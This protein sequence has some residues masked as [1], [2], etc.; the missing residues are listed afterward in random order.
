MRLVRRLL[1]LT[2]VLWTAASVAAAVFLRFWLRERFGRGG[3]IPA[4]QAGVLLHPLRRRIHPP[5]EMLA[6]FGVDTGQTVLELGPGP[7]YFTIEAARRV[8]E[9]GRILCVDVQRDMLTAL[10]RRLREHGAARAHP[11]LGDATR[12]PLADR[13]VDRAYLV[14]VLGEVPDRPAAL[15]ELRRVLRP[16]GLLAFAET[17]TDPDYVLRETL[18]DLCRATGFEV[19]GE[20]SLLLGYMMRFRKPEDAPADP[21]VRRSRRRAPRS[22]AAS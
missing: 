21:P 7:G 9:G 4:S 17:F 1:T 18:R 6:W 5:E 13:S 14:T 16:G 8:G 12:L 19:D 10:Q 20:R 22:E 2:L 15:A 11:V 3:P